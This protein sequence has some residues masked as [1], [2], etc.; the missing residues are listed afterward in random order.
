MG[1]GRSEDFLREMGSLRLLQIPLVNTSIIALNRKLA[2]HVP[3]GKTRLV[4]NL[5]NFEEYTNVHSTIPSLRGVMEA[6]GILECFLSSVIKRQ[7]RYLTYIGDGDTKSYQN[8]VN[9]NPYRGYEIVKAECV[10]HVQKRVGT[11]LR[12]FKTDYKELMPE[13]FYAEKK[14]KKQKKL[15]FYLTH[16]MINRLQNY[17]GIAIRATCKTS[18]PTMRMAVGAVLFHC[19]EAVDSAG[20]HHFC[21]KSTT[22]WCKYQ[23]DQVN[24]MSDYIEKPD[25][26]IALRKKLEPIFRELS[27]PELLA[28]CMHGQTQN[29]NESINGVIWKRCPKDTFVGRNVIEMSVSSAVISFNSGKRGLF[30]VYH[31]CNLGTGSYTELFCFLMMPAKFVGRI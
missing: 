27:S 3:I 26:P 4:Q 1:H 25:L 7:L 17:F 12:K 20:R 2:K 28:K 23:V 8:V 9:A 29:N 24:S 19:S 18:V 30:D 16:K 14:D 21:P 6:D 5:R 22:S 11:R 15:T 13:S 31:G 10:G